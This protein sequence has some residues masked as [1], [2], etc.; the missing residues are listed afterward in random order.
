VIVTAGRCC[1]NIR[2]GWIGGHGPSDAGIPVV[3]VLRRKVRRVGDIG[4][5]DGDAPRIGARR[6]RPFG[7]RTR[8]GPR[9]DGGQP[10]N[11][12]LRPG[13]SRTSQ[14]LVDVSVVIVTERHG[15]CCNGEAVAGRRERPTS[16]TARSRCWRRLS[17]CIPRDAVSAGNAAKKFICKVTCTLVADPVNELPEEEPSRPAFDSVCP[18]RVGNRFPATNLCRL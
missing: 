13:R 16:L 6:V 15:A 17:P 11:G 8:V 1:K 12:M 4:C 14:G 2:R 18:P 5:G 9:R 10:M 7:K 3:T